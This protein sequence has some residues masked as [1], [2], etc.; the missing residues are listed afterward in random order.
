VPELA[1]LIFVT[2]ALVGGADAVVDVGAGGF[3]VVAAVEVG[4]GAADVDELAGGFA[5][6]A[7]L[8]VE[9]EVPHAVN[10]GIAS[11]KTINRPRNNFLTISTPYFYLFPWL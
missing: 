10:A 11:N 9:V 1:I 7:V 2:G 5:E 6:V 8:V 3:A 4:G